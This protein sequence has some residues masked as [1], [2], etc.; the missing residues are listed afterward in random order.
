MPD[1][2]DTEDQKTSTR[3]QDL[4]RAAFNRIAE[5]GFEGLRTRDVAADAG[6]NVA[7]L[8]YYFPTKEALIRGVV[9]H[10]MWRFSQ[11]MPKEGSAAEQIRWHLA[12]LRRLLKEDTEL[13][14]VLAELTMRAPRDPVIAGILQNTDE[15]W[16]HE[17]AALLESA[18]EQ[19]CIDASIDPEGGAAFIIAAIKGLSLPGNPE[20]HGKRVDQTFDQ[21]E[22]WLGLPSE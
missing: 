8:H 17:V 21:L 11:S 2:M 6:V 13:F 5:A 15:P 19:G 9:G 22:R 1:E 3:R 20:I 12:F 14:A 10:A 16:H 4:V 7:T 18:L